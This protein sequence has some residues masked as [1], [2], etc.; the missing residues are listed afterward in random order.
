MCSQEYWIHRG[1]LVPRPEEFGGQ[2]VSDKELMSTYGYVWVHR[3]ETCTQVAWYCNAANFA[4]LYFAKEWIGT[5]SGPYRLTYFLN[6]WFVETLDDP[7]LAR[8]RIDQ[9]IAKSDTLL[10]SRVYVREIEPK[11]SKL[12]ELLRQAYEERAVP[13]R[14]SIECYQDSRTSRFKVGRIG[15]DSA[16]AQFWGLSTVSYPCLNGN[17]YDDVVGQAY[18]K[19]I[20][21]K[22]PNY[23]HVYAAMV[24]PD[25]EVA[26]IPY[27]RVILPGPKSARNPSVTV[28]SEFRPVEIVVV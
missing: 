25:G 18:A 14:S 4:S 22:Q 15:E 1:G 20:A 21:S 23:S 27:Q 28:V 2:P 9:L 19:V 10:T 8:G 7:E 11:V 17:S 24:R 13:A 16:I 3:D 26:W 6:G 5:F 12:P